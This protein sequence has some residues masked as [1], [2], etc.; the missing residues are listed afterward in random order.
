MWMNV[1]PSNFNA[2]VALFDYA[3]MYMCIYLSLEQI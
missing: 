1:L 2:I 3:Y